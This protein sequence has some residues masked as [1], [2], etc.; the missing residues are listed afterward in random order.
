MVFSQNAFTRA[1]QIFEDGVMSV[2][3]CVLGE[4]I[5]VLKVE[6]PVRFQGLCVLI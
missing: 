2:R 1:L 5:L 4:F 6:R 3:I